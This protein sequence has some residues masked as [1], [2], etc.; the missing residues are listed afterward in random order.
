MCDCLKLNLGSF[1]H[2]YDFDRRRVIIASEEGWSKPHW[3]EFAD[4]GLLAAQ[5]RFQRTRRNMRQVRHDL[6]RLLGSG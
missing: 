5:S 2:F 3:Q 4:M 1:C 6:E